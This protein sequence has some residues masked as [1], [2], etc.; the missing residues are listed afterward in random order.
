M[1]NV[2]TLALACCLLPALYAC[3]PTLD[4]TQTLAQVQ[5]ALSA[6]QFNEAEIKL[7]SLLSDNANDA[8]VRRML[9]S[10]LLEQGNFS[11]AIKELERAIA[12]GVDTSDVHIDLLQA[13]LRANE[14]DDILAFNPREIALSPAALAEV[15]VLK[16]IAALQSEKIE[17]ARSYLNDAIDSA[18]DS[19]FAYLGRAY[20]ASSEDDWESALTAI[21]ESIGIN[22]DFAEAYLMKGQVLSHLGRSEES[23]VAYK[24]YYELKPQSQEAKLIYVNSLIQNNQFDEATPLVNELA[25][26][27]GKHPIISQLKGVLAYVKEDYETAKRHTDDAIQSGLRTPISLSINGISA[28]ELGLYEQAYRSLKSAEPYLSAEHPA[29][30]LLFV[31]QTQLGFSNEA[32]EVFSGTQFDTSDANIVSMTGLSFAQ[33]GETQGAEEA[34]NIL[35]TFDNLSEENLTRKG[36][37]RLQLNDLSGIEDL[38]AAL[39][40]APELESAQV[41]LFDAYLRT[42]D[43]TSLIEFATDLLNKE[44]NSVVGYNMLASG[45]LGMK[46]VEEASKAYDRALQIDPINPP[47]LIHK[48]GIYAEQQDYASAAN[49]IEPLVIQRPSYFHGLAVYYQYLVD[50]GENDKALRAVERANTIVTDSEEHKFLL[51]SIYYSRGM[52]SEAQQTLLKIDIN[53]SLPN[54]YWLLLVETYLKMDQWDNAEEVLK[55]WVDTTPF[56]EYA[57][58]Y[59]VAFLQLYAKDDEVR[60]ALSEALAA[61]PRSNTLKLLEVQFEI[62]SGNIAIARSKLKEV[63]KTES[64]ATA[65]EGIE[66][67]FE[68]IGNKA[69]DS[70]LSR[71]LK[72]YE[73]HPTKFAVKGIVA[74]YQQRRDKPSMLDFLQQ[75]IT[76]YPR[77]YFSRKMLADALFTTQPETA[78]EHYTLLNKVNP[79][80]LLVINNLSWLLYEQN[81]LEEASEMINSGLSIRNDVP[82]ILDTAAVIEKAKGN[83]QEALDLFAKA[84]RISP[85]AGIALHYA[86]ALIDSGDKEQARELLNLIPEN[87]NAQIKQQKQKLLDG[88]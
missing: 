52:L 9:G 73:K 67:F 61:L 77:D 14:Y 22:P 33:S 19:Q 80:D 42:Q 6:K 1:H 83:Q 26:S 4:R 20:I 46:N 53:K 36:M 86:S 57:Q 48:A 62:E 79:N 31:T 54:N 58:I 29:R 27:F 18:S 37:L 50:A 38:K 76:D 44:P 87:T 71:L 85:T 47:S 45:H 34:L 81:L 82:F 66:A 84:Y 59:R 75:R 39:V 55:N 43:F 30:K 8:E 2:K 78:I 11:A 70:T 32:A 51:A 74:N 7:K 88:L 23:L 41:A 35:N 10:V 56:N 5:Q 15:Y 40:K 65:Y 68:L 25:Q 21:E 24:T 63:E 49:T 17:E 28:H 72:F 16:G 13:K 60:V 12:L 3:Q 69:D 64:T